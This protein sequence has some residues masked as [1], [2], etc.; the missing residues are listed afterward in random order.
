MRRS[1]LEREFQALQ[2][3]L[4]DNMVLQLQLHAQIARLI[5]AAAEQ[6]EE[7]ASNDD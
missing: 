2:R 4:Q 7:N 1:D 3:V 5:T 6:G